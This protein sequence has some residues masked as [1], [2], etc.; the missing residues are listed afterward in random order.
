MLVSI[1]PTGQS[2]INHFKKSLTYAFQ[3]EG[4]IKT[5]TLYFDFVL[6]LCL[7]MAKSCILFKLSQF[8]T[9]N[10]FVL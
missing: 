9:T 1:T 7:L 3:T 8:L 6:I 4:F 5:T 2:N 10:V